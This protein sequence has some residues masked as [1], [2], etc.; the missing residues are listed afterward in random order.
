MHQK[1][2]S[3]LE[4]LYK[5]NEVGTAISEKL[6]FWREHSS[7]TKHYEGITPADKVLVSAYELS[8]VIDMFPEDFNNV[9]L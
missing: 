4:K 1:H 7:N 5:D 2:Q 3:A 9:K 8:W 6:E